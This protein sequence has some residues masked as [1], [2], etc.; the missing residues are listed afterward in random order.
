M[1]QVI[2]IVFLSFFAVVLFAAPVVSYAVTDERTDTS[3][4]GGG[5]PLDQGL[6]KVK[7][8]FNTTGKLTNPNQSVVEFIV[9]IIRFLLTVAMAIDVLFIIIGGYQYITSAGS[10]EKA[11]KGRT[12]LVN[13]IIGLVIIILSYVIV[14]V[15]NRTLARS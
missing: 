1:K 9:T 14:S 12:T 5:N 4:S 11:T 3:T 13:A 7:G 15:V 6:N 8:E 2:K 10:E